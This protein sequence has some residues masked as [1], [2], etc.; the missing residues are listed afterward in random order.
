[1]EKGLHGFR[2]AAAG[3]LRFAEMSAK[4]LQLELK[5]SGTFISCRRYSDSREAS[6]PKQERETGW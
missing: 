4:R 6:N 1:M 5:S 2:A 3:I